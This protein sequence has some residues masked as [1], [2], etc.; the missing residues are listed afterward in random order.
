MTTVAQILALLKVEAAEG[1]LAW[2]LP[3]SL[4]DSHAVT[5]DVEDGWRIEVSAPHRALSPEE[6]AAW[7]MEIWTI[8]QAFDYLRSLSA[9]FDASV[10]D[11][12]LAEFVRRADR[13]GVR[14]EVL[15]EAV[16]T[17]WRNARHAAD[18][19]MKLNRAGCATL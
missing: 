3:S 7:L 12:P 15:C 5:F 17:W 8:N 18:G 14:P 4:H 2:K 16:V 6:N 10:I 13:Y 1:Y 11:E 9:P 19:E